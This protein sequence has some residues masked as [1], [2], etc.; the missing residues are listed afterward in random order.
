MRSLSVVTA[1]AVI[2]TIVAPFETDVLLQPPARFGYWLVVVMLS[3]VAGKLA[4]AYV[5]CRA[6]DLPP[7]RL[8]LA[9]AILTTLMVFGG[10]VFLNGIYFDIWPGAP[11]YERVLLV[12]VGG[13]TFLLSL[14]LS[15]VEETRHQPPPAEAPPA[16]PRLLDRLTPEAQ[17]ELVSISVKDHYVVV[18]TTRGCEQILMRLRDAISETGDTPGLQIHRS[19]WVALPQVQAVRRE[20]ARGVVILR[21]GR[22]LPVSRT[23]L[24]DLRK[25]GLLSSPH[26]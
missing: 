14:A 16:P 1:L 2:F 10:V 13:V 23:Y 12:N 11:D 4:H 6:P 26:G 21:D 5:H 18:T 9:T 7:A 17:G 3:A 25:S 20:G 19:H 8:A 24:P 15:Y 22:E